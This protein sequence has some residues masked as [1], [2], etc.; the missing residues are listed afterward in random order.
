MDEVSEEDE[1]EIEEENKDIY[2]VPK[3]ILPKVMRDTIEKEEE[4]GGI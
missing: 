4:K 3:D 1:L 2:E